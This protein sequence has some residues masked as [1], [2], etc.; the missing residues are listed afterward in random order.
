MLVLVIARLGARGYSF[1]YSSLVSW[2]SRTI[3]CF[4][5][6]FALEFTDETGDV[7]TTEAISVQGGKDIDSDVSGSGDQTSATVLAGRIEA[8]LEA[9]PNNVVPDVQVAY[10]PHTA[11]SG[12]AREETRFFSVSFVANSGDIPTMGVSYSIYD[13]ALA[14]ASNANNAA[15]HKQCH[16]A[17]LSTNAQCRGYR[18]RVVMPSGCTA[19]RGSTTI[20]SVS[21]T[22]L[23]S[24]LDFSPTV[25]FGAVSHDNTAGAQDAIFTATLDPHNPGQILGALVKVNAGT[26][27]GGVPDVTFGYPDGYDSDL[28]KYKV[29]CVPMSAKLGAV[30]P[31]SDKVDGGIGFVEVIEGN[32]AS[33]TGNPGLSVKGTKENAECSNRGICDY[34]SGS[35]KCFTGFTTRDCSVQNSLAMG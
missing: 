3:A 19:I 32:P 7:W 23:G 30:L 34:K 14:H 21:C 27:Y 18:H 12:T 29:S 33:A 5:G 20:A 22:G 28:N 6:Y 13:S 9:L 1:M 25:I 11:S 8:A 16:A 4:D 24:G 35:C 26:A 17:K 15:A 10:V 31:F 2:G